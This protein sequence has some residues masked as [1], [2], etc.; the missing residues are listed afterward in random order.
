MF[1]RGYVTL[2]REYIRGVQNWIFNSH[3]IRKVETAVVSRLSYRVL[4]LVFCL[5]LPS[6]GYIG[7]LVPSVGCMLIIIWN[8]F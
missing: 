5:L 8:I 6:Q 3:G 4:Y 7:M 1:L 2:Q